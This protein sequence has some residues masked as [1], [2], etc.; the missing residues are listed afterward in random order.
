MSDEGAVVVIGGTRAI[1]LGSLHSAAAGR[2]WSTGKEPGNVESGVRGPGR[3]D[4]RGSVHGRT[5]DLAEPHDCF[6]AG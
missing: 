3:A 2:G 4:A 6:G 5:F 1:G